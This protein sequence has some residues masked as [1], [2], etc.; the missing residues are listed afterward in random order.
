MNTTHI[1]QMA[2][3]ERDPDQKVSS[4]TGSR[5]ALKAPMDIDFKALKSVNE[6]VVGWIY[7]EAVPSI[8]YPIVHGTDNETSIFTEPMRRTIISQEPFS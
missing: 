3:T 5:N 2:V 1:A 8:S 6:D 4:R 7:V